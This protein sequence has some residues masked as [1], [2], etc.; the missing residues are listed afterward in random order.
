MLS[1]FENNGQ[2][3]LPLGLELMS[4]M[5]SLDTLPTQNT[6]ETP[7]NNKKYTEESESPLSSFTKR[8]RNDNK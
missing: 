6:I 3:P 4:N 2:L 8:E 7:D 5:G 1:E